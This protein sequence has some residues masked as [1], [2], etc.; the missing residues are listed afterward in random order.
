MRIKL[1]APD[2]S[3]PGDIDEVV[4]PN[5]VGREYL[6]KLQEKA[7][8]ER[9][10]Q[11][12]HRS[13]KL[14][15]L[16]A[17]NLSSMEET[18]LDNAVRPQASRQ[19]SLPDVPLTPEAADLANRLR[20]LIKGR[21]AEANKVPVSVL[22]WGPGIDSSSPL[23]ST[24]ADLRSRL[25]QEGHAAFFSEELCDSHLPDSIRLQQLAQAQEFD[26]IVSIPATPGSIGEVHD[27]AA[28]R[29]V[30]GKLFVFLNQQFIAGYSAQSLSAL[31]SV[32]SN[33]LFYYPS[34]DE[35]AVII[36]VTAYEVQRIREMKYILAGRFL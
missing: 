28:D 16:D 7:R 35:A 10:R 32:V 17:A 26:L 4:L 23:S 20:P 29:R 11:S 12:L 3:L 18:V 33:R 30:N 1:T 31:N 13:I 21:L 14:K 22:V 15:N 9:E 24:R 27:F 8:Q 6:L 34:E 2:E 36:E 19:S 5:K 25:R